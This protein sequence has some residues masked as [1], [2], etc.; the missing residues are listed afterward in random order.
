MSTNVDGHVLKFCKAREALSNGGKMQ[1]RF[2]VNVVG[3]A[4]VCK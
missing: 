3:P 1:R 2:F 4:I